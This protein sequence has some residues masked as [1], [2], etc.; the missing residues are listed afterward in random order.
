MKKFIKFLIFLFFKKDVSQLREV[1][2]NIIYID[3]ST[4]K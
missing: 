1:Q 3:F 2:V 4:K